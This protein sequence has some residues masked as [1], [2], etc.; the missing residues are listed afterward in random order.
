M[1]RIIYII[2]IIVVAT[3]CLHRVD[4]AAR[5]DVP[6]TLDLGAPYH[7]IDI[8]SHQRHINWQALA[9]D[10][11]VHF[12][13]IKATEGTTYQSPHYAYNVTMAH[14]HN[15]LVGSYHY[16]TTTSPISEQFANFA[17]VATVTSQDLLPMIDIEQRGSWSRRQL[18]DSLTVFAR[19]LEQHYGSRPMIYSTMDFYNANL[20]PQF[21]G[22][23]LYIA[24][25]SDVTPIINWEGRVTVWQYSELG[26]LAG[27]G[28]YVDLC[29]VTDP[30]ALAALALH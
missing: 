8:S 3:S 17:R 27:V 11:N 1:R 29:R 7:G 4:P 22:Y 24:R 20:A 15:L 28:A 30:N 9:A 10:S 13:Y 14:H 2:A 16:L 5:D 6:S 26:L 21:N 12:V 19:L 25:Y 18:I 23:P